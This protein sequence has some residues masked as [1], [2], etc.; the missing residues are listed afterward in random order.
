MVLNH[1]TYLYASYTGGVNLNLEHFCGILPS[2]QK[3]KTQLDVSLANICSRHQGRT[4]NMEK[5]T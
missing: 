5:N 4:K 2:L 3:M 1:T